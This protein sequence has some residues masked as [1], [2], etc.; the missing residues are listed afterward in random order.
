MPS[1]ILMT[2]VNR[3]HSYFARVPPASNRFFVVAEF[4]NR[5]DLDKT[6]VEIMGKLSEP[7]CH[8]GFIFD[9]LD[10]RTMPIIDTVS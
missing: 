4:K 1:L 2:M 7:C 3:P 8:Y 9:D 10:F 5:L 6:N